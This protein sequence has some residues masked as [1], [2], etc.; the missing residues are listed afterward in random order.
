[1]PENEILRIESFALSETINKN[2]AE[3][4]KLMSRQ[5]SK[6][7]TMKTIIKFTI[8][9][10]T[11][12]G[13]MLFTGCKSNDP[14]TN[15][16]TLQSKLL[17]VLTTKEV[18]SIYQNTATSGGVITS[19][20]GSSVIARGVC[21]STNATPTITDSK[22]TDGAGIGS[23]TSSIIGLT[24][25]TSYFVRAYATTSKGTGYGGAYQIAT[26]IANPIV[27]DIDGNVYHTVTIGTQTWM[28]S[29]LCVKHY[30]N[31]QSISD[32]EFQDWWARATYGGWCYYYD[33]N[34]AD[35]TKY[36][37]LYNSYAV[38]DT[39]K[40]APT[41]WHVPTSA[42]WTT[43]TTYL[44]GVS[45]AGGKL[46]EAGTLN[47]T[48]PNSDATNETGFSAFPGGTRTGTG[49]FYDVGKYGYWWSLYQDGTTSFSPLRL[50]YNSGFAETIGVGGGQ[51][52]YSVRCVRD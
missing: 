44:G 16:P 38:A 17:P 26:E 35:Y 24:A 42:E 29:N 11:L 31:G 47:W 27:T 14:A 43:L 45:V 6:V 18:T 50:S 30:R 46:K 40:I 19:D 7:Y 10:C 33:N 21:W 15:E 32:L 1:M 41:G 12:F 13:F 37:Y 23:F 48:T 52:G 34:G 49:G 4:E 22:T 3:A 25:S 39:R 28:T 2:I 20:G 5:N 8:F 9:S 36:G 51:P